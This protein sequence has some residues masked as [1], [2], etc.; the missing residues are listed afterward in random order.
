MYECVRAC[1]CVMLKCILVCNRECM[2]I[3]TTAFVSSY[4]SRGE[5]SAFVSACHY[6]SMCLC[7]HVCACRVYV[8]MYSLCLYV[9]LYARG[10]LCARLWHV[11][12]SMACVHVYGLCARLWSVC[13]SMVCVR[14]YVHVYVHV[15]GLCAHLELR[16]C[17]AVVTCARRLLSN[18]TLLYNIKKWETN[19]QIALSSQLINKVRSEKSGLDDINFTFLEV[20]YLSYFHW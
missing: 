19:P 16:A 15:Y 6:F 4:R 18:N 11:C 1:T 2:C 17:V 10:S 20:E 9:D 3:H 13:T 8:H 7:T 5:G 14:I 12:T